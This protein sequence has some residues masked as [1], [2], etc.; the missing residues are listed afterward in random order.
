MF[1]R[2]IAGA[3]GSAIHEAWPAAS[4]PPKAA[5]FTTAGP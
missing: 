3:C 5:G 2:A 1:A 4:T